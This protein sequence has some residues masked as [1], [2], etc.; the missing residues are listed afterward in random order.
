MILE[1]M[2]G[3]GLLPADSQFMPNGSRG[4]APNRLAGTPP[5]PPLNPI[6]K[7]RCW[8]NLLISSSGMPSSSAARRN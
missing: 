8:L 2:N 1:E 7:R 5:E 3:N 4:K 6:D